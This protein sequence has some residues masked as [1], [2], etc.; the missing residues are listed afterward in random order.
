V[1]A[2]RAG[3]EPHSVPSHCLPSQQHATSGLIGPHNLGKT[4]NVLWADGS[5]TLTRVKH[6]PPFN[7]RTLEVNVHGD[8]NPK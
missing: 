7:D 6:A 1:R 5:I 4:W 8:W 3:R 2:A